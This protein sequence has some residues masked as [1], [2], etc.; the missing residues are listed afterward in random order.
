MI[1]VNDLY[2]QNKINF[3]RGAFNIIDCGIRTGKTFWA[4][5]Y[6]PQFTSDNKLSRILYLVN[7]TSLKNQII[8]DYDNCVEADDVWLRANNSFGDVPNKIGIMCY[9]RFQNLIVKDDLRFLDSI[10]VICW[11]ECDSIFDFAV[12]AFA[13][14]RRSDFARKDMTNEE[15]LSVIQEYSTKKEYLPLVLLGFWEKL[16]LHGKILCIGLSAS[17]TRAQLYYQNLVH[18]SNQGKLEAGYRA[19]TDIYFR[20]CVE[21]IKELHP[22][23]GVAYW[24]YS[25]RIRDNQSMVPVANNQG[26]NAIELHSLNSEYADSTPEQIRVIQYIQATGMV[27]PEYDF[28]IINESLKRGITIRDPRFTHLIINSYRESDRLQAGR[29]IFP[30]QQHIKIFA[31]PVPD[32]YLNRWLTFHECQQLA[33]DMAVPEVNDKGW[34]LQKNMSWNKLKGYLDTMGYQIEEKRKSING[35]QQ[36]CSYITGEWHDIAM[37]ENGFFQL[38][39]AHSKQLDEELS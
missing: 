14:A 23:E 31:P 13:R 39:E 6:L 9:Q 1:T 38:A 8:N 25:R 16:I 4:V 15:V 35:K 5:N 7:A 20:D 37:V 18:A 17:P 28:V 33:E 24:C 34:S 21:H 26:F 22:E 29:Q 10:E 2:Q 11:D 19:A 36:K 30:Y 27:P 3:R 12:D 32:T